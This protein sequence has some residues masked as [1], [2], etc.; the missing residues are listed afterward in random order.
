MASRL[1]IMAAAENGAAEGIVCGD[2]DTAFVGKDACFNLPVGE[3]RT[4]RKGNVF[5]HGLES[6]K[7]EGVT[8]GRGLKILARL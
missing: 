7:D 4:E 6:L 1:V 8:R 3:S 2:V 5:M